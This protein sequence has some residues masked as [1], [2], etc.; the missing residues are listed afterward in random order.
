MFLDFLHKVFIKKTYY[1]IHLIAEF[2][3]SSESE[4]LI[5]NLSD[6]IKRITDKRDSVYTELQK[7]PKGYRVTYNIIYYNTFFRKK[8]YTRELTNFFDWLV[9]DD[10]Y[11]GCLNKYNYSC[12][13]FY[14][15]SDLF[16]C[17]C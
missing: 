16:S 9:D 10:N 3:V 17:M 13:S 15:G 1:K 7:F 8:N 4:C 11:V 14:K 5:A 2:N 12:S 6:H